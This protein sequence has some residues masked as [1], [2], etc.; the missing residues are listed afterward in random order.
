M[1]VRHDVASVVEDALSGGLWPTGQE[2]RLE[3]RSHESVLL[4][5]PQ[6]GVA[7]LHPLG[8]APHC[9]LAKEHVRGSQ[10]HVGHVG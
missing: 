3:P 1:T 2:Q 7:P 6:L 8:A 4:Q 10:T 9:A 5:L